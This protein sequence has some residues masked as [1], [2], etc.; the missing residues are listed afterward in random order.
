MSE[1]SSYHDFDTLLLHGWLRASNGDLTVLRIEGGTPEDDLKA[2]DRITEQHTLEFGAD[3]K[4]LKWI[5]LQKKLAILRLDLIL[6]GNRFIENQIE[7][8]QEELELLAKEMTGN[9]KA[10]ITQTLIALS[11]RAGY[12]ITEFNVTAKRFFEMIRYYGKGD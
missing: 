3:R 2:W 7:I 9:G 12:M 11:E 5:R 10:N 6:T 1:N 8:V 4:H